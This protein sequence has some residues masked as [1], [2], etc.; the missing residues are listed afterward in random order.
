MSDFS[1]YFSHKWSYEWLP[2]NAMLWRSIASKCKLLIDQPEPTTE[3]ER[4]YFIARLES[5][6]RRTDMMVCCLPAQPA[7]NPLPTN[8]SGDYRFFD[9]SPYILFE[10]RLAERLDLPRFVLYD[11]RSRF[12]PPA[13]TDPRIKYIARDFSELTV[14]LNANRRDAGLEEAIDDWLRAVARSRIPAA[15]PVPSR[16]ALLTTLSPGGMHYSLLTASVDASGF[17]S[18][19]ALDSSLTDADL[20][21]YMRGLGLLLV[22]LTNPAVLPLMHIAHV[23][24]VPTIRLTPAC[25]SDHV[26]PDILKGHPAGYQRDLVPYGEESAD[27]SLTKRIGDRARAVVRAAQPVI[28][29]KDGIALLHRRTYATPTHVV[30]ISHNEKPGDRGLVELLIGELEMRGVRYWEYGSE[31]RAGVNWREKMTEGLTTA[32]HVVALVAPRYEKSD[33]CM[34]EWNYAI[35]NRLP[36]LP[37][38]TRGRSE[39]VVTDRSFKVAHESR[40]SE[41]PLGDQARLIAERVANVLRGAEAL[42]T[43]T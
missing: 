17:D 7:S 41:Y 28:G 5:L 23:L 14:L 9:C 35:H 34:E 20:I 26:L 32:T 27:E 19:D 18:P 10:L 29:E 30:F 36:L 37:F 40:L 3:E 38:L 33:G 39:S 4:P 25:G 1:A 15:W 6:L 12:R 31:N 22:D 13:S 43:V 16:S 24:M 2:I 42:F 11:R 8:R 21:H